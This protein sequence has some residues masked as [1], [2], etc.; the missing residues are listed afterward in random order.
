MHLSTVSSLFTFWFSLWREERWSRIG[1]V[2]KSVHMSLY[3]CRPTWG[4]DELFQLH[5]RRFQ[6]CLKRLTSSQ[7]CFQQQLKIAPAV[8]SWP[9]Y[10]CYC[11]TSL[12]MTMTESTCHLLKLLLAVVWSVLFSSSVLQ[13]VNRRL[14]LSKSKNTKFNESGQLCVFH[15]VSSVWSFYILITVSEIL[16]SYFQSV[17]PFGWDM[18]RVFLQNISHTRQNKILSFWSHFTGGLSSASKQSLG[19]LSPC[20]P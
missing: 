8:F 1:S 2:F 11:D 20:S 16:G 15:L 17:T 3:V 13:K 18:S 7:Q 6:A 19:E 5:Q 4:N 14:H 12:C 10:L 9:S